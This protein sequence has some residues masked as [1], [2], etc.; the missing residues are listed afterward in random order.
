MKTNMH[1]WEIAE[2]V[3]T[4]RLLANNLE[5]KENKT[6]EEEEKDTIKGRLRLERVLW[7]KPRINFRRNNHVLPRLPSDLMSIL[8]A[9]NCQ[10]VPSLLDSTWKII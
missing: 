9:P 10:D 2:L 4:I 8:G 6:P 5:D 1:N 7:V 3:Y